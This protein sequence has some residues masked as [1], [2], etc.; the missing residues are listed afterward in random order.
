MR[1]NWRLADQVLAHSEGGKELVVQI[2][3]VREHHQGRIGHTCIE[4]QQAGIEGHQQALPGA[5]RMPNHASLVV[6][7]RL[8]L[9]AGETVDGR[10]FRQ[11]QLTRTQRG[12]DCPFDRVKLMVAGDDFD[13]PV[14]AFTKYGE[15]TEK[16][17]EA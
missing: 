8:V 17:E 7:W 5:L 4:Y 15:V 11:R 16:I 14:P 2:V 6:A 3:A 1:L 13:Q 10:I 12:D 9:D